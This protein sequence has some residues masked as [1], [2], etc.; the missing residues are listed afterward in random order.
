[1]HYNQNQSILL[2]PSPEEMI[3]IKHPIRVVNEAINK[4]NPDYS[5]ENH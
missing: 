3:S 2:P 4:I 1:M 5:I